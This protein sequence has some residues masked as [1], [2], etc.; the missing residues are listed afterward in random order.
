MMLRHILYL[1]LVLLCQSQAHALE[2]AAEL[3]ERVTASGMKTRLSSHYFLQADCTSGGDIAVRVTTP[4]KQ[5]KVEVEDQ[6]VVISYPKDSTY[7]VCNGKSVDG[8]VIFYKSNDA[9]VGKDEVDAEVF[10]PNGTSRKLRILI[11]VK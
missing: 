10:F 11:N 2:K 3:Q 9:F 6:P 5:G 4:A 8:K 7:A 1:C